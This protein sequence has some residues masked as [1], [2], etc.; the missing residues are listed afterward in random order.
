L[1]GLVQGG[2]QVG[3]VADQGQVHTGEGL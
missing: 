1:Q 2:G 3:A